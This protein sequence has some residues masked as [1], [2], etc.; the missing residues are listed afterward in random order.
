VTEFIYEVTDVPAS[1]GVTP[2]QTVGPFFHFAL[3]Y[4]EGSA[5]AGASRAGAI[6][7]HGY[8]YDGE[9]TGLPDA[10]VEVWQADES[11]SFVEAPGI[12]AEPSDDGFRGFGR[13]ATDEDGHYS[14]RTVK[15]A[16]VPTEDGAAQAP[17]IAMS[18]FARGMLRRVVTRV[19]FDDEADANDSDPLLSSLEDPRA[20]T[21]VAG[22]DEGGYRFDVRL[23]GDDETVFLDV[24]GH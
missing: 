12:F 14:F 22:S 15:P 7:L 18:V 11:G 20:A 16:G 19:Y 23:Q 10:L 13:A 1:E 3:P 5:V 2:W 21:L 8:V 6:T 24:A 9:G 17:H 4:D